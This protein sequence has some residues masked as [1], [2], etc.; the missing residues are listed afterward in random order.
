MANITYEVIFSTKDA[1]QNTIFLQLI[2]PKDQ[3]QRATLQTTDES[4][5]LTVDRWELRE[6]GTMIITGTNI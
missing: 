6:V 4:V 2:I 3:S 5:V 1:N